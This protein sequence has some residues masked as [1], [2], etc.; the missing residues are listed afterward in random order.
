[1]TLKNPLLLVLISATTMFVA[2]SAK[3][4]APKKTTTN[5]PSYRTAAQKAPALRNPNINLPSSLPG[6]VGV[7]HSRGRTT[8]PYVAMTYDD[9][10][11]PQNTPRLLDMLRKRN[12][13]ATFYV[14]GRSVNL[15]P[16][17]T[18]RIVAEGHEIGNHT[19]TH[20]KLTALSDSAVRSELNRTR[21]AIIASTG[22]K[23][24]TMRPPY[25]ALRQDQRA[26]I[27]KEY[28]YPTI[29]W[30]VDPEDW[31]RPGV[32]VVTSRIVNNTRN[33]GIVLAHDLHKP[34]VDAMPGTLDGL[35]R[36]GF[37]FVTVSQLLALNPSTAATR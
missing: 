29:L 26:W 28:G 19:W 11:H 12:I 34:T 30:S 35:L 14:I 18:R 32:S 10:P 7:T 15:Y 21:D 4:K 8:L 2:C 22:V 5:N 16:Q 25:G 20:P 3:E 27:Y 31:R 17:I 13:K 1:M 23:P 36:K 6:G 24:R 37:K 33:G 9:G